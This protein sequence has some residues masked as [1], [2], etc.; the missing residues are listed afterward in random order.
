MLI[1]QLKIALEDVIVVTLTLG[2]WPRLGDEKRNE[3]GEKLSCHG[4]QTH[5]HKFESM[6]GSKFQHSK[7]IFILVVENPMVY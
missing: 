3:F 5:F 1:I 4:I 6:Q 7:C 2:L